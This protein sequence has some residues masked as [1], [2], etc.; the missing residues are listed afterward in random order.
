M[1]AP[2]PYQLGLV[3][4]GEVVACDTGEQG[5]VRTRLKA[6]HAEQTPPASCEL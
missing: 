4:N 6:S 1:F 3:K 5:V 2:E